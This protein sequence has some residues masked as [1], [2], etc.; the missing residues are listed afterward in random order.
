[1]TTAP[2]MKS[3]SAPLVSF[4]EGLSNS[5]WEQCKKIH[6]G[7]GFSI[8]SISEIYN[9]TPLKQKI[10]LEIVDFFGK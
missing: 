1:M 4:S 2:K 7:M 3:Q 9:K 5:K 6:S 8:A 10:H